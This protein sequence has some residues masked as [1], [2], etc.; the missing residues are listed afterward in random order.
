MDESLYQQFPQIEEDHWWFRGRRAVIR[1]LL[2][3][4][5]L[6]STPR[7]L[8]AGCGT[9]RNLVEYA[10]LGAASG[11]EPSAAAV[12][13]CTARGLDVHQA[14]LEALPFDDGEFDLIC[15]SDVLEHIEAHEAALAEL[16]RVAGPGACLLVTVPAYAWLWSRH[17]ETHHHVRRYTLARLVA[18]AR[19]GGWRPVFSSYFNSLL[20]APV[21]A[22]RLAQRLRPPASGSDY[23]LTPAPLNAILELP[24]RA[25]ARLLGAGRRLPAGLS[26]GLVCEAAQG[27][28]TSTS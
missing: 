7:I 27:R 23:A 12:A 13:A 9:G 22:V 25:E 24:M 20:L 17:D 19:A 4:V 21:A 3:H 16:R 11:V 28:G 5:Q 1:G 15:A 6:G 2:E 10:R 8:D 26:I 14:G 18:V